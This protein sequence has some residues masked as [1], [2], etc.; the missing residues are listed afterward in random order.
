MSTTVLTLVPC[1]ESPELSVRKS[2]GK[3]FLFAIFLKKKKYLSFRCF[4]DWIFCL[5]G[6][7]SARCKWS[8]LRR[9]WSAI[10][11]SAGWSDHCLNLDNYCDSSAHLVSQEIQGLFCVLLG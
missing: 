6:N 2:Q 9:W 3:V 4:G 7:Q 1:T 11:G 10:V 5:H 8:L